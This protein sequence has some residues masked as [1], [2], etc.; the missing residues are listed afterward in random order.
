P[1]DDLGLTFLED[2]A[3]DWNSGHDAFNGGRCGPGERVTHVAQVRRSHGWYD[4]S[5]TADGDTAFPGRRGLRAAR[6]QRSREDHDDPRHHH[7]AAGA[8]RD[9]GSV[10]A[11]RA[12]A[13]DGGTAADRVRAADAV[14]GRG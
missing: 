14:R 7:A 12:H 3:H 5:V 2:V 10:R 9:R 8:V 4:L 13:E 6:T 1:V 11:G